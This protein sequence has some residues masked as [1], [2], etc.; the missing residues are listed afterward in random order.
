MDRIDKIKLLKTAKE[1]QLPQ[2]PY[3]LVILIE[4]IINGRKMLSDMKGNDYELDHKFPGG[5]KPFIIKIIE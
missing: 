2:V 3:Q 1:K 5:L 4:E